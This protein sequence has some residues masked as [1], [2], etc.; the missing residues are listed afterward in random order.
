MTF[1]LMIAKLKIGLTIGSS[2]FTRCLSAT[3]CLFVL[4]GKTSM[5]QAKEKFFISNP[6]LH[7]APAAIRQ[8]SFALKHLK[9][10][11]VKIQQF[12]ILA[13]AAAY[14]QLHHFYLVR[15]KL[16]VLILIPSQLKQRRQMHLKMDL[17]KANS[18]L[19]RVIYPIKLQASTMLL[20]PT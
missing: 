7:L 1:K 13:A 20:L 5:M 17:M 4:L 9:I 18:K 2:I 6:D 11:S 16:S 3:N 10:T 14:F 19:F 15:K 8:Q 12:L